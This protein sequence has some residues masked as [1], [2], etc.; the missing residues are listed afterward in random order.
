M[1]EFGNP[2]YRPDGEKFEFG[3]AITTHLS[4]GSQYF[5]GI[6][7]QEYFGGGYDINKRLNYTGI[8]RFRHK[9]IYVIPSLGIQVPILKSVVSINGRSV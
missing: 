2:L 4:Q 9:C 8:T 6:Y 5:N 7:L 3:Y 1:K